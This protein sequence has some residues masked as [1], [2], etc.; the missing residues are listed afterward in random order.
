MSRFRNSYRIGAFFGAVLLCLPPVASS[1]QTIEVDPADEI[2]AIFEG[3]E[4]VVKIAETLTFRFR[5]F[6]DGQLKEEATELLYG[7][8]YVIEAVFETDPKEERLGI[9]LDWAASG[10]TADELE[11]VRVSEGDK[12]FYR[13]VKMVILETREE[14][15]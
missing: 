7:I 4:A 3:E 9:R 12:T 11:M 5:P 2:E 6:M 8:P 10:A 14:G 15:N 1:G 13:A